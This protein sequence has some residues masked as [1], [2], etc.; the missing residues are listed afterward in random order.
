M[1]CFRF[2]GQRPRCCPTLAPRAAMNVAAVKT[3]SSISS[4]RTSVDVQNITR[5]NVWQR[6]DPQRSDGQRLLARG[7]GGAIL[8]PGTISIH[9]ITKPVMDRRPQVLLGSGGTSR[10]PHPTAYCSRVTAHGG[11]R[12]RVALDITRSSRGCIDNVDLTRFT[13]SIPGAK[14]ERADCRRVE[15]AEQPPVYTLQ[16]GGGETP[17]CRHL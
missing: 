17:R 6:C 11:R 4:R 12:P 13:E 7:E 2:W 8:S 9:N 1:G 15:L 14:S 10:E 16:G 5:Q 3:C